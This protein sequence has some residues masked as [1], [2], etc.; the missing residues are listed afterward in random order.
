MKYELI[1]KNDNVLSKPKKIIIT[2]EQ[3]GVI[4]LFAHQTKNSNLDITYKLN[5]C[6][7]TATP[8]MEDM[9]EVKEQTGSELFDFEIKSPLKEIKQSDNK[10]D[11]KIVLFGCFNDG[12]PYVIDRLRGDS[13]PIKLDLN[14]SPTV[15]FVDEKSGNS[16]TLHIESRNS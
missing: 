5:D 6:E 1:I 13:V 8:L 7:F 12:E 3:M 9:F 14:I 10:S 15:R 4:E 11:S 2:Q 16:F